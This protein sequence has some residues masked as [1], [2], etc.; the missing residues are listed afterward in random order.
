[1]KKFISKLVEYA[2]MLFLSIYFLKLSVCLLYSILPILAGI[3]GIIFLSLI[4]YRIVKHKR[5]NGEW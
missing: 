5:D 4:I 1:M 2:F 3:L